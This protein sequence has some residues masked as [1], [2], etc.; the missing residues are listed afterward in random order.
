VQA[1][2]FW[3]Q[4]LS[5]RRAQFLKLA[6]RASTATRATADVPDGDACKVHYYSL[7]LIVRSFG[8]SASNSKFA[9][10]QIAIC[11]N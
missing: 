6:M 5:S 3:A 2:T 7:I 1:L 9:W 8:A 4:R 10:P 11:P